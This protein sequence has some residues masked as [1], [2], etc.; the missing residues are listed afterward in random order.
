MKTWLKAGGRNSQL[1]PDS[2]GY[3]EQIDQGSA[4]RIA[5]SDV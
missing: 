4:D 2:M 3:G 1:H 5:Q